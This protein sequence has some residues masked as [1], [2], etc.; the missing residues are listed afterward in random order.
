MLFDKNH[1]LFMIFSAIF[2]VAVL[3]LAGK[4]I[5]SSKMKDLFLLVFAILS[6]VLHFS[7]VYVT[8]FKTGEIVVDE[9]MIM[10]IYPC[11]IAMWLLLI[12][13]NVKNKKGKVF[14]VLAEFAFYLGIVGGVIGIALNEIYAS[15]PSLTD[16][17]VLKGLLSHVT[18]LVTSIYLLV[19]GYI[20]IRVS[21]VMSVLIGL[22][23]MLLDGALVIALYK[24]FN[25]EPPNAMYLLEPPM[26][27]MQ[28]FNTLTMG[29]LALVIVF[30]ITAIYEW[31]ALSKKDR[32]YVKL[33][34]K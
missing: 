30:S 34:K 4:F 19:G 28:W 22:V 5:K 14:Q 29:L 3:V 15:T 10:P 12:T 7:S 31:L 21:N 8:F 16:W 24:I 17:N 26:E 2:V 13:A 11:H 20:K 23:F 32:W 9:S 33:K 1:I 25:L 18:M 6:V 27:N